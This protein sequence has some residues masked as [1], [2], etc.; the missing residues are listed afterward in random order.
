MN[1]EQLIKETDALTY[2]NGLKVTLAEVKKEVAGI[3]E[4]G[5]YQ[6]QSGERLKKLMRKADNQYRVIAKLAQGGSGSFANNV[7]IDEDPPEELKSL[8]EEINIDV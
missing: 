6:I 3:Q 7:S 1:L 2:I 5:E 8:M 4:M